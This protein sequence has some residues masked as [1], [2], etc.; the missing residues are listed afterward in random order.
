MAQRADF[1]SDTRTQT[2][3]P[4]ADFHQPAASTTTRAQRITFLYVGPP[5]RPVT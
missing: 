4:L 2:G 3:L 5:N 1:Q